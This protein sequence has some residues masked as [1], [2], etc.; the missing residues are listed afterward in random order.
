[1]KLTRGET[2]IIATHNAGKLA[3]LRE[4]LLP[5][6]LKAVSAAELGLPE[7]EETADTFT[8][9]AEIKAKAA[10]GKFAA[11]AD[12]S[13]LVIHALKGE[14]GVHSARFGKQFKNYQEAMA[15]LSSQLS[16]KDK[17]AEFVCALSLAFPNG[18]II[19][20]EARIKGVIT[21]QRGEYGFG[22]DAFFLP[23]GETRTFGELTA[24][25]K[26]GLP[27]LGLG[28]SHRAKAFMKLAT[29]A[30]PA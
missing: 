4:L 5:Y 10:C 12:D 17:S 21:E 8:G 13:G 14:P 29:A 6:G 30:F 27:P 1:M 2:V 16:G 28:L 15:N 24:T 7:P 18:E 3:E 22:Y 9:N 25:E 26:H 19:T 11:L 23:D 20:L